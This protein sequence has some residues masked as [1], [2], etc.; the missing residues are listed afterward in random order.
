M[1]E[2]FADDESAGG[3]PIFETEISEDVLQISRP[4]TRWLST[5]VNGGYVESSAAYNITVPSGWGRRDLRS[6]INRRRSEAGFDE[7]GPAL[8]TG[9]SMEH[10]RVAWTPPTAVVVTAGLSNPAAFADGGT[11]PS[12]DPVSDGPGHVGTVNILACVDRDLAPGA[13]AN[14]V[15][16]IAEAKTTALLETTGFPGTTT[17]AIVAG[18]DPTGPE[19]EFSGSATAVGAATR[20]CVHDAVRACISAR[21][22][23]EELP[24]SVGEAEHGVVTDIETDISAPLARKGQTD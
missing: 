24:A 4:G 14:L 18:C 1:S 2:E 20:A 5:G 22:E 16:V 11:A 23:D 21:Y 7:D 12:T 8:L 3:N 15:A 17:D 9:V 10:A 6:Y 19:A 13:L